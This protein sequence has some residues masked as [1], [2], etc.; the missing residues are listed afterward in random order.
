MAK[1]TLYVWRRKRGEEHFGRLSQYSI[2][3]VMQLRPQ[4][5]VEFD[6]TGEELEYPKL[7][8]RVLI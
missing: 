5:E 7:L 4:G 8:E 6:R 3:E 1:R 2:A